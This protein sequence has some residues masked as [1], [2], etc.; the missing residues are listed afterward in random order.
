MCLAPL[1]VT[2]SG[3]SASLLVLDKVTF[4]TSINFLELDS[5]I[6]KSNLV[7][8]PNLISVLISIGLKFLILLLLNPS[9]TILFVR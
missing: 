3:N 5:V 8:S 1:D 4:L 9:K 2:A 7:L 6:K